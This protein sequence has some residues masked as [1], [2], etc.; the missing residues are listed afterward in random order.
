MFRDSKFGEVVAAAM[1][2]LILTSATV[3]AAVAPAHSVGVAR[4]ATAAAAPAADRANA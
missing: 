3:G 2:A 1:G 4:V